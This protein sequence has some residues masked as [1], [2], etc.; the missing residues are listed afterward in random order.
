MKIKSHDRKSSL[1]S[2]ARLLTAASLLFGALLVVTSCQP[3]GGADPLGGSLTISIGQNM[4]RSLVPVID[5]AIASYAITGVGPGGGTF[6]QSTSGAAVSIGGLA[7]GQWTVTVNGKNAAGTVI[8][9]GSGSVTVD[10]G[11]QSNLTVTVAPLSGNGTI[12]LSVSW[13]AS[14]VQSPSI[15]AQLL[16][17]SGSQIPLAFTLG[18]GSA[19]CQNTNIPSGYYT[20]SIQLFDN[21]VLIMGA[22]EVARIVSTQ[23]TTGAFDFTQASAGTGGI[24]FGITPVISDPLAVTLTGQVATLTLGSSMTITAAVAG[25]VGNVVYVWYVNGQSKGTGSNTSPSLTLGSA[26]PV[27][28]YR[29]DMT[30]FTA[31]G[32]R[33]GAATYT[34]KVQ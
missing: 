5:M 2:R 28:V 12:N 33:A 32:L 19:S 21:G 34:F 3:P 31:D 26:L 7:F 25:N 27:G 29:L 4:S 8:G 16:S 20:L 17:S 6:S 15:S 13:T 24:A 22:V 10:T 9:R 23:T 30:A 14:N 18:T 1:L 11:K